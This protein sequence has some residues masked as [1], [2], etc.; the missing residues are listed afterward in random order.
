MAVQASRKARISKPRKPYPD[1]P[2]YAH[3]TGRWAKKIRGKIHYFGPW[4][5]PEAALERYKRERDDLY[6]GRTPRTPSDGLDMLGLAN[7]FLTAKQHL[8]ETGELSPRTFADYRV[9][10]ERIIAAFGKTRLVSDLAS[11][12]FLHFRTELAKTRGVVALGNEINRARVVFKFAFDE[13]LIASP[14]RYGSSFKRPNRKT[15]RA[16]RHANGP[17]MFEAGEIKAMLDAAGEQLKAMILL[18]INAGYGNSDVATLPLKALDLDRGW[19]NYPRPK[20]A[21]ERRAPLWPETIAA[22]RAALAVRPS[23]KDRAEEGLVFVTRY[24]QSWSKSTCDNPVSKEMA[25]LLKSLG[26]ERPGLNFYALRHTFETIGG[27]S[28]DQ[29]AVDYVMGHS[30]NDMASIYRERISDERLKAVTD[31]VR[32]WLFGKAVLAKKESGRRKG[33]KQRSAAA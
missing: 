11:D 22:L 33:S 15:L 18:G 28:R 25:K 14:V 19:V 5:D 7:R 9:T 3:R 17:K 1:F 13:G 6:A 24:G 30:R 16:A 26:I 2:L 23:P 12:D 10:C 32:G 27:E 4:R 20:T 21:V 31:H 29:V 8:V